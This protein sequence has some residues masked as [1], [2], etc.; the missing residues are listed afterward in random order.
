MT[1]QQRPAPLP[2][3]GDHALH[4]R[5]HHRRGPRSL[6]RGDEWPRREPGRWPGRRSE[7]TCRE[8]VK[9]WRSTARHSARSVLQGTGTNEGW[10]RRRQAA[11][12][13]RRRGVRTDCRR[14]AACMPTI[15][16]RRGRSRRHLVV[17]VTVAKVSSRTRPRGE[18]EGRLPVPLALLPG[19]YYVGHPRAPG[20]A[21]RP[22][23]GTHGH[24]APAPG[25]IAGV[26]GADYRRR[27]PE[28]ASR[29]ASFLVGLAMSR[30]F[31]SSSSS[32]TRLT[33]TL[34]CLFAGI[35][36]RQHQRPSRSSATGAVGHVRRR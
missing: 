16:L 27:A 3:P 11:I 35:A 2:G 14:T 24:V 13:A 29:A 36:L 12:A 18:Q 30:W 34:G 8:L 19:R 23:G 15:S 7:E 9:A 10:S 22:G 17:E 25:R 20:R 28:M 21:G 31:P 33:T 32:S 26:H 4:R 6:R 5:P 1:I